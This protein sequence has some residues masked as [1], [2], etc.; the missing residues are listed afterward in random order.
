VLRR[1]ERIIDERTGRLLRLKRPGIVLED[2]TCRGAYHRCCPRADYPLLARDLARAGRV[3]PARPARQWTMGARGMSDGLKMQRERANRIHGD[4][5]EGLW[6]HHY[7]SDPLIEY[8]R[9]RRLHR[10]LEELDNA[11]EA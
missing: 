4:P 9:D 1:V 8:L 6:D 11:R 5:T 7:T 10:A 2:V 3:R